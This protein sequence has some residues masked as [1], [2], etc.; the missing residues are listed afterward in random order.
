VALL[1][2]LPC[3]TTFVGARCYTSCVIHEKV[4]Y[5]VLAHTWGICLA[6]CFSHKSCTLLM[7]IRL[8]PNFCFNGAELNSSYS[9]NEWLVSNLMYIFMYV[10]RNCVTFLYC[11]S[12]LQNLLVYI[13]KYFKIIY[14]FIMSN[15]SSPHQTFKNCKK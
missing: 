5:I 10:C 1:L 7:H 11:F 13:K 6:L 3:S 12:F 8:I 9:G 4:H 14:T 15:L 2:I